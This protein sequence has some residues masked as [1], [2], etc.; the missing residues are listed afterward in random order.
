MTENE[1]WGILSLH[2]GKDDIILGYTP[3]NINAGRNK[4]GLLMNHAYIVHGIHT[5]NNGQKL[6][7]MRNPN[8]RDY[9]AGAYSD[10]SGD[11]TQAL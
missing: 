6:V 11:W 5:L 3:E 4:D 8:G 7:K 2:D 10:T 1:L 9:Y